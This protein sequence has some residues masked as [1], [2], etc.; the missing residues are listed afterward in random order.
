MTKQSL[1]FTNFILADVIPDLI[2]GEVRPLSRFVLCMTS[3]SVFD[4]DILTTCHPDINNV[5]G[6]FVVTVPVQNIYASGISRHIGPLG[7]VTVLD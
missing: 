2:D 3:Q 7:L 4:A 6:V 1:K 5:I